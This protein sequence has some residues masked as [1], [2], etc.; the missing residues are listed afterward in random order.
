MTITGG[1]IEWEPVTS[2]LRK[3]QFKMKP[4]GTSNAGAAKT[5]WMAEE[6]TV[7]A[8]PEDSELEAIEAALQ[9]LQGEG[10]NDSSEGNE[11][12]TEDE[13]KEILMT[14]MK[15]KYTGPVQ[16]MNYKEVQAAKNQIR[17]NRGF[18]DMPSGP[19][20]RRPARRDIEALKKRT[21]CKN[22]KELGHWHR[23]CPKAS[24][25]GAKSSFY[26]EDEAAGSEPEFDLGSDGDREH[27]Y[28]VEQDD[29][30]QVRA[31]R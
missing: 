13:A 7:E 17:N 24:Q 31:D 16:S 26:L 18:R 29:A 6:E 23:E 22:C 27:F 9:E 5:T 4:E 3:L 8:N 21:R 19:F 14:F 11:E 2:A 15:N 28:F 25:G 20:P 30:A 1:Q 10:L 12:Y